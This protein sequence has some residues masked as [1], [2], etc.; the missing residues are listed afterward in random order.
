MIY[1]V[2]LRPTAGALQGRRPRENSIARG[3]RTH[4]HFIVDMYQ[5]FHCDVLSQDTAKQ[6]ITQLQVEVQ[7]MV[8]FLRFP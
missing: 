1:F 2:V 4:S 3:A 6:T 5:Q 8:I 7:E